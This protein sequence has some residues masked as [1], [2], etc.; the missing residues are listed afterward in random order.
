M[1]LLSSFN[2]RGNTILSNSPSLSHPK[3][4]SSVYD[5]Y[6]IYMYHFQRRYLSAE[7]KGPKDIDLHHPKNNRTLGK[8]LKTA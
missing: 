3:S 4:I 7:R 8:N 5:K 1:F 6:D 2:Y